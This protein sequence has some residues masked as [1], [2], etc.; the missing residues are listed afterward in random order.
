MADSWFYTEVVL[1]VLVAALI[2][3]FVAESEVQA[4]IPFIF[5]V[6]FA[7]AK[8]PFGDSALVTGI[9]LILLFVLLISSVTPVLLRSL[10]DSKQQ[11]G[12][13]QE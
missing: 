6:T 3:V 11:L 2:V 4:A 1:D 13:L 8:V 5:E 12:K 10:V 9:L 7:G